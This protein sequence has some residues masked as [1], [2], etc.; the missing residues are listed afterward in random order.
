MRNKVI[1][2][3]G[4]ASSYTEAS[5]K[6]ICKRISQGESLISI[7]K[8]EDMPSKFT[9]LKWLRDFPD[10]TTHYARAREDQAEHY[11]DQIADIADNC[12]DD[13]MFL[14]TA[15]DDE[16]EPGQSAKAV[17]KHSAIQRARLQIDARKWIMSKLAPK[18]Y[19]D[20]TSVE[21][22]GIDGK[23]IISAAI[24]LTKYNDEQLRSL[25]EL[26]TIIGSSP[27]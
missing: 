24:D 7:C 1:K 20:K 8:D 2:K 18:K 9:V 26:A 3:R 5:G 19:G 16:S 25:K 22:G 14:V 13:V 27:K 11:L 4:R 23:P 6:E 12:T 21:M 10:F 17:I 15:G